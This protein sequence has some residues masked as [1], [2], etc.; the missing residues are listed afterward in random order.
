MMAAAISLS[1]CAAL[2]AVVFLVLAA[3]GLAGLSLCIMEL[4]EALDEGSAELAHIE[5]VLE[6]YDQIDEIAASAA[7]QMRQAVRR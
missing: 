3:L 6:A 4:K 5:T 2:L 7:R 1:T